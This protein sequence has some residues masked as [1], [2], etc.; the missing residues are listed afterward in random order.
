MF[1]NQ[2][3]KLFEQVQSKEAMGSV[4]KLDACQS[5]YL[6]FKGQTYINIGLKFWIGDGSTVGFG[7]DFYLP[8]LEV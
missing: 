7:L 4:L 6:K 2:K 8:V 5:F 3:Q 1:L